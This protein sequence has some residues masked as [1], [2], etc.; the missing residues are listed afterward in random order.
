MLLNDILNKSQP[1]SESS[2]LENFIKSQTL[3]DLG[4]SNCKLT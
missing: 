1:S 2:R 4:I 3:N